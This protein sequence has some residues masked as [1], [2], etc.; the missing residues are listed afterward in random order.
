MSSS[1]LTVVR[2]ARARAPYARSALV[3]CF[4]LFDTETLVQS[5]LAEALR[6]LPLLQD[7]SAFSGVR[8]VMGCALEPVDSRDSHPGEEVTFSP[9]TLDYRPIPGVGCLL[10]TSEQTAL[11]RLRDGFAHLRR[12]LRS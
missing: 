6:Q 12:K 10:E 3:E 5:A 11:R 9:E 2:K 8:S 4:D 7:E 1:T